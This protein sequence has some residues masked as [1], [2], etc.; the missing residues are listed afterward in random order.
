MSV[1]NYHRLDHGDSVVREN[2]DGCADLG[3]GVGVAAASH[4]CGKL[5]L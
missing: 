2:N 4:G 3:P 5:H 1:V